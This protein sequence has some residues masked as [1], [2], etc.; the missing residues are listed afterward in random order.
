MWCARIRDGWGRSAGR[1]RHANPRFVG[2]NAE[3]PELCA[4]V[5]IRPRVVLLCCWQ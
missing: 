4:A 2:N 3:L 5:G 1:I